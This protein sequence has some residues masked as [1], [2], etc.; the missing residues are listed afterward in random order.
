MVN[1]RLRLRA[2]VHPAIERA[3]GKAR[4]GRP[5]AAPS[6][7]LE[8]ITFYDFGLIQSKFIVI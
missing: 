6:K 3:S 1:D 8:S 7:S 5:P 2:F 4:S